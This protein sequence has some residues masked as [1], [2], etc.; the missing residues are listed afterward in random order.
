MRLSMEMI[1]TMSVFDLKWNGLRIIPLT[2]V[3][4][5]SRFGILKNEGFLLPTLLLPTRGDH[6]SRLG[7]DCLPQKGFGR[8]LDICMTL[9]GGVFHS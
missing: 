5:V 3:M 4:A 9:K 2:G 7:I 6:R 1:P 8:S